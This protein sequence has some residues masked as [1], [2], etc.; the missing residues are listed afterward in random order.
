MLMCLF[1]IASYLEYLRDLETKI[2]Q[3]WDRISASLEE[4]RKSLFSKEGCLINITSDSK[5]LEKS[6]QYIAKFL[7]SLP[8]APS[9][10]SDPW[11][12]RLPSVNEAIV[13]P[14][15]VKLTC[16]ALWH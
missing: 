6:G 14:T 8:S 1:A 7:D 5:N 4:M 15:Q 2:D 13:I 10:G 12:S 9:L 16:L 11:V 3:D